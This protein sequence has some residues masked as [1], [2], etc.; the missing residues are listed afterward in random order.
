MSTL[1]TG[2]FD[3]RFAQSHMEPSDVHDC[4]EGMAARPQPSQ[5]GGIL[6]YYAELARTAP[7]L[8]SPFAR[9]MEISDQE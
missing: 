4:L 6:A 7:L 8:P 1:H 2:T 3:T 9:T 5:Q